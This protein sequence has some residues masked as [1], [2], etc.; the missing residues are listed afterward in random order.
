MH[1]LAFVSLAAHSVTQQ[2]VEFETSPLLRSAVRFRLLVTQRTQGT[3]VPV[4]G[5][6]HLFTFGSP[7]GTV[8]TVLQLA[9]L[10]F[11]S[12]HKVGDRF[13]VSSRQGLKTLGMV[14]IINFGIGLCMKCC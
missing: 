9:R 8:D 2:L 11:R 1:Y 10:L 13:I 6:H 14:L 7:T 3:Y 5:H 12:L 4:P